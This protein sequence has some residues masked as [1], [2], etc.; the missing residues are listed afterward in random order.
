[1]R[2]PT[3]DKMPP[4]LKRVLASLDTELQPTINLIQTDSKNRGGDYS[5]EGVAVQVNTQPTCLKPATL[6]S[7]AQDTFKDLAEGS[8]A[9][10]AP[11]FMNYIQP[12]GRPREFLLKEDIV[13]D[14][15]NPMTVAKYLYLT[16]REIDLE[17]QPPT[18]AGKATQPHPEL[19]NYLKDGL[20]TKMELLLIQILFST[21]GLKLEPKG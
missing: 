7:G 14:L 6:K 4:I 19:E 13:F 9:T 11:D 18:I 17:L 15:K 8:K 10:L 2:H 16:S 5:S 12:G 1:M 3:F 21:P 20:R